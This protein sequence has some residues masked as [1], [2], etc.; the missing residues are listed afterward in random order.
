MPGMTAS[1]TIYVEEKSNTLI[2]SGK[3]MRFTP[4]AAYLKKMMATMQPPIGG[5]ND[6][7]A[8]APGLPGSGQVPP[9]GAMPQGNPPAGMMPGQ[10]PEGLKTVWVKDEKGGI[11]PA[12]VVTG[13][14]NGTSI[15][16]LSGLKAGDEV[17][18]SMTSS[19]VK[20]K[21]STTNGGPGGPFPF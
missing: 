16:I 13:I 6:V 14:D 1:A 10:A 21:A 8:A 18:I 9:A 19:T 11:H 17:I 4:D 5:R 7:Q 15:E 20:K 3:A 12:P 2:L